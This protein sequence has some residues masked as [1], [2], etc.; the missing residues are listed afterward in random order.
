MGSSVFRWL[1]CLNNAPLPNRVYVAFVAQESVYG[2]LTRTSSFFECLNMRSLN[3]KLNGRDLLVEPIRTSFS[4][5]PANGNIQPG[6]SDARDGYLSLIEV[7]NQIADKTMP[8]RF[9]YAN[10]FR[11]F[12]VYALEMSKCGEK[13][14]GVGGSLDVEVEFDQNLTDI[15]A[16]MLVFTEKTEKAKF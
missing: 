1:N 5:D 10:Y 3:F 6:Q 2:R 13:T 16:C 8:A 11:G 15:P 4:R 9:S 7:W 14:G 12:L